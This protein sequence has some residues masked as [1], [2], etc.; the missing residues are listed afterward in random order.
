MTETQAEQLLYI[1][2][3]IRGGGE[4]ENERERERKKHRS[5]CLR[6]VGR[7]GRSSLRCTHYT[8]QSE[9][10]AD[11]RVHSFREVVGAKTRSSFYGRD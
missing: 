6:L 9:L 4:R 7:K 2:K 11:L 3:Q 8:W 5:P 1:E 10:A